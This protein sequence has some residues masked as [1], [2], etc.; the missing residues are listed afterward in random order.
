MSEENNGINNNIKEKSKDV[1]KN[2]INNKLQQNKAV[3][4]SMRAK[5]TIKRLAIFIKLIAKGIGAFIISPIGIAM[6]IITMA[7][8]GVSTGD[9]VIGKVNFA[10]DCGQSTKEE[11]VDNCILMGDGRAK[12]KWSVFGKGGGGSSVNS[13]DIVE[14][15]N[16]LAV[17]KGE[18]WG[19]SGGKLSKGSEM[20]QELRDAIEK[21][22]ETDMDFA[23]GSNLY[24]KDC[25]RFVAIVMKSTKDPDYPWGDTDQQLDYLQKNSK[26]E[27]VN[28]ESRQPGDIGIIDRGRDG[29]TDHTWL[30]AGELPDRDGEWTLEA[31]WFQYEPERHKFAGCDYYNNS[32]LLYWYRYVG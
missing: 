4:M 6:I 19:G 3:A 31:S 25:G 7:A 8:M 28:C 30:Y 17:E 27:K 14:F 26:Y 2:I 16:S 13:G 18:G 12:N 1:S 24:T 9:Q 20:K 32:G 21:L 11:K 29:R 5:R 22:Y 10:S 15:A 23:H